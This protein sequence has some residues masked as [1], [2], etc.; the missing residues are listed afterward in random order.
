VLAT[1]RQ[2]L[3]R[4]Q[5]ELLRLRTYS[6]GSKFETQRRRVAITLGFIAFTTLIGLAL[7]DIG[8]VVDLI[9]SV[10]GSM[11]AFAFPCWAYFKLFPDRRASPFSVFSSALLVLGLVLIPLGVALTVLF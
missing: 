5:R 9:G 4:I 11:I 8:K 2:D 1:T 7:D 3:S 6:F 10:C